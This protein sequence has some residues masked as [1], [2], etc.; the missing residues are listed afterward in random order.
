MAQEKM[1]AIGGGKGG[2]GKSI[3]TIALGIWLAKLGKNVVIVDA[4]L[5]G[6]NLHILMGMRYP[7]ATL[8]DFINRKVNRLEDVLIDT[9]QKNLRLICGADDILSIANPKYAQKV[10]LLNGLNSLDADFIL[11][12]L[13]AGTSFNVLDF[14]LYATG[15]IVVLTPQATSLQN[16]YGFIKSSLI[17]R[18]YREFAQDELLSIALKKFDSSYEGERI[19]S[20]SELKRT[21]RDISEEKYRRV[22]QALDDF[23]VKIIVNMVKRDK[24]REASKVIRTVTEKYLD[25]R[26]TELGSVYYDP[27]IERSVNRMVPFLLD[28]THSQAALSMYQVTYQILKECSSMGL[29]KMKEPALI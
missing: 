23:N 26:L 15:K 18:L 9:P 5:G 29:S 14:F 8:D 28:N 1:W 11:L 25:I 22:C 13:G 7:T 6:A 3:L 17:R 16:A 24:D 12:D 20:L 4:D 19:T 21:V 2:I 27:E 10:K